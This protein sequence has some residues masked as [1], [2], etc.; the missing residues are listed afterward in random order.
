MESLGFK[1]FPRFMEV[2]LLLA[3]LQRL[4]PSAERD[5]LHPEDAGIKGT[6]LLDVFNR[7]DEVI[8][9]TNLHK[10]APF[11]DLYRDDLRAASRA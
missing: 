3:E 1:L 10:C 6:G 11:C 8:N 9:S 4:S 2:D 5:H 7:E